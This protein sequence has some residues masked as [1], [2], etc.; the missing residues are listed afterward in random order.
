MKKDVPEPI[1]DWALTKLEQFA[2]FI[3][4]TAIGIGSFALWEN[5]KF[6]QRATVILEQLQANDARQDAEIAEIKGKMVTWDTL[7]RI[8]L[9]LI[10]QPPEARAE[11]LSN[12]LKMELEGR[13]KR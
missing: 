10:S 1:R 3:C 11:Q 7:K 4:T 13:K 6:N 9:F 12:A 8:E 5:Y 2:I